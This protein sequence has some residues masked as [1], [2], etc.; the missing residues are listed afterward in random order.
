MLGSRRRRR[1]FPFTACTLVL[2]LLAAQG[3]A[4]GVRPAAAAGTFYPAQ[5]QKLAERVHELLY[6]ARPSV[7][8]SLREQTP[9]ALIVPHAGYIY[10][11]PTAAAAYKLL[12]GTPGPSR[13][14]LIGPAHRASLIGKCSVADFAQYET[15][16]GQVSVDEE[17][18]DR[19]VS[20]GPF[21]RTRYAHARE[22]GLEV[23]LPFLQTL[24]PEP[25]PIVPILVGRMT[26]PDSRR[27]AAA[28]A[29]ILGPDALLIISTDFTHYGRRFNYTPFAGATGDELARRIKALDM[30]GV[31][32]VEQLDP[33]GFKEYLGA[34]RPTICGAMGISI[35]LEIFARVE[36]CRPLFLQWANSGEVTG[37]YSDCVSYVAMA[38]YAPGPEF[39]RIQRSLS[40]EAAECAGPR[41]APRLTQQEQQA[42]L[43]L[44][45]E[46]IVSRLG[47]ENSE[48]EPALVSETLRGHYGA[49]VTLKR[50]EKLRG[51]VGHMVGGG[52]L[53]VCVRDCARLAAFRDGRFRP[54]QR[55]ELDSLR[56]EVSV[57][58]S[59]V[60]VDD[61]GEIKVGRDG[62]VVCRGQQRGLLLPQ[63]AVEHGWDRQEFLRQTCRKAGLPTDA[64]E[65]SGTAILRFTATVFSE[66]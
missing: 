34:R 24:W 55:A 28:I 63:V 10:S 56:I 54:V 23:Q 27:A 1:R 17:C 13:V 53:W 9:R 57:L 48:P 43:A 30:E 7:P 39:E 33:A 59:L 14:V 45:R 38:L 64:W 12:E 4:A 66:E 50:G 22:H 19:L 46:S 21:E 6:E 36:S 5:R 41:P 61:P 35:M 60:V 20:T 37:S 18:C 51:C 42:L 16:L 3:V 29:G 65:Q 8:G 44:A 62:L 11:G 49:F 40:E 2:A 32:H 31:H 26:E 58:G 47:G 15:P 52:P 25:P